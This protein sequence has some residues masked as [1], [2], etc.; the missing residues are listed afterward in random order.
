MKQGLLFLTAFAVLTIIGCIKEKTVISSPGHEEYAEWL[1]K[2]GKYF[3]EGTIQVSTGGSSVKGHLNWHAVREYSNK[4]VTFTVV[5]FIFAASPVKN[6][7]LVYGSEAAEMPT[8]YDM[9]FWKKGENINAVLRV[10]TY[11]EPKQ[12]ILEKRRVF[13]TFFELDGRKKHAAVVYGTYDYILLRDEGAEAGAQNRT[14][15][16]E[17]QVITTHTFNCEGNTANTTICYYRTRTTMR[18]ICSYSSGE[19]GEWETPEPGEGGGGWSEYETTTEKYQNQGIIDSLQGYPCAQD[20]LK[21]LPN[22]DSLTKQILSVFGVNEDVNVKFTSSS[23]LPLSTDGIT[24]CSGGSIVF[25]CTVKLNTHVLTNSSK[26]YIVAVFIHEAL[27]AFINFKKNQLGA[28]SQEFRDMFPIYGQYV[29]NDPQHNEMANNYID[30]MANIIKGFNPSI[31][32]TDARALA[33]GGLEMTTVWRDQDT[34]SIMNMNHRA[35]FPTAA[36]YVNYNL[37]KCD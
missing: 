7:R 6:G 15:G 26:D 5:P 8:L 21:Q 32:D 33:W 28:N 36:D 35:K 10:R 2:N 37:K 24:T 4:S 3:A 18:T 19:P 16:C 9:V 30:K 14:G 17:V 22:I 1:A 31:S 23:T 11:H 13:E 34:T 29:G 12:L 27:H 25:D 20:V